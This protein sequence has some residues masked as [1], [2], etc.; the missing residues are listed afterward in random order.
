MVFAHAAIRFPNEA[1][2]SRFATFIIEPPRVGEI[3]T[4][5]IPTTAQAVA[6]HIAERLAPADIAVCLSDL[7]GG[8]WQVE[9]HFGDEVER[10]PVRA[11][12]AAAAG[13]EAAAALQFGSLEA[14]D[15]VRQ[16]LAGLK[17]VAAGRFVVHGAHDR[18]RVP[19][20]R[21]GIEIEAALAFGTGHHATTR[22]CLLALDAIGKAMDRPRRVPRFAGANRP[23][24]F[25][26]RTMKRS[27]PQMRIL[28]VGTGSGVLAIAAARALRKPVLAID[29][30]ALAVKTARANARHN[31]AGYLL[32]VLRADGVGTRPTRARAPHDLIFANILLGPLKRMATPLRRLAAP[33]GCIVLSGILRAQANAVIAAYRPLALQRRLD[34]DGWTTLVLVRRSA[35]HPGKT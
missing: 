24:P 12:V 18:A 26:G 29:I 27:A 30:D 14:A 25:R 2:L 4:E 34:I 11:A 33:G 17:P 5:A 10:E 28:D 13:A 1:C 22:G 21:I 6:D 8:R 9:I 7:G 20:N 31:R 15:W 19:E 23:P 3:Q 16:S 35:R 32:S